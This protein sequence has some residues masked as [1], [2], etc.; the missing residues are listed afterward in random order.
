MGHPVSILKTSIFLVLLSVL[1]HLAM[2]QIDMNQKP[3]LV[4]SDDPMP[5]APAMAGPMGS[6]APMYSS[7]RRAPDVSPAQISG[8]A[9]YE[10]TQTAVGNKIDQM[11]T[12]LFALQT[13]MGGMA[14]KLQSL[15]ERGQ[16]QAAE[17]NANVATITTALQSGTTPGNPRLVNRLSNA[18]AGLEAMA[19]NVADM[20]RMSVEVAEL[21]SMT[22]FLAE[23]AR[24]A[25]TLSGA[26]EEDHVRLAQLED[27]INAVNVTID[28]I[29]NEVND[30]IVRTN[31]FLAAENTN[32][33][34]LGLSV[35]KGEMYGRSLA[36]TAF[37]PAA[38]ASPAMVPAAS[39]ASYAPTNYAPASY[40]PT[41]PVMQ[42]T[43]P[44]Q[45]V[46]FTP[47][48]APA[49]A[50]PAMV[51]SP[52]QAYQPSH[53]RP[54]TSLAPR[55]YRS[56][57]PAA[58]SLSSSAAL[59][60]SVAPSVAAAPMAEPV[61]AMPSAASRVSHAAPSHSLIPANATPVKTRRP[62]A[63]I[64]FDR[65]NVAYEQP[66]YK[67]VKDALARYPGSQIEVVAVHP[68]SDNAAK[69][70]IEATKARRHAEDVLRSL[71]Q[72]GLSLDRVV[73]E[74]AQSAEAKTGE[75]HIFIR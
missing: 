45:S 27:Q 49:A 29:T 33:R 19:Q 37:A 17:Y 26:I 42:Q 35:T 75:V 40:A 3:V 56:S 72:M 69:N 50:M 9:Y 74:T 73:P 64:K 48:P 70:A 12:E 15:D 22:S 4:I 21:S 58:P 24:H 57:R 62:L 60:P 2:A 20:N 25:Y 18:Q 5:S 53:F 65:P 52:R 59:R 54:R 41:P 38:V 61:A 31:G 44:A 34:T 71:S 6:A 63:K 51:Y 23:E 47:T 46:T 66:V 7:P 55:E 68:A 11:R 30:D 8:A 10:P 32:L 43:A 1:P 36:N 14:A 13:R 67:A 28:R 39:P 16:R